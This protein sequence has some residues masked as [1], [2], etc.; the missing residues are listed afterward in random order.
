MTI[1]SPFAW[2]WKQLRTGVSLIGSES[3]EHYWHR[4][5]G[6]TSSL[7]VRKID[8]G[9]LR[10]ALAAGWADFAANRTDV[11]FLCVLYPIVGIVLSRLAF[12]YHL[13]PLLFPLA[14]GFALIG[15]IAGIGL[16][17]MSRRREAGENVSWVTAFSVLRAPSIGAITLLSFALMA[18]FLLWLFVAA[19]IYEVI[20]GSV[21]PVSIPAF[22][23]TVFGTGAGWALI[24][25]GCGVGF[26]FAALV[27]AIS[28]ISFPLLLDQNVG[29]ETAVRTSLRLVAT[30]PWTIALWGLIIAVALVLGS[31]PL[32]IG[33][34]VVMPVLGHATWHLYRRAVVLR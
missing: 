4:G 11:I 15:P 32:L 5:E 27:L 13:L 2:G 16:N 22:I 23:A 10:A 12:G 33:L 26:L 9:D 20:L 30:N 19:S 24:G 14:A 25:I 8:A 29:V 18:I 21:P 1:E 6:L 28:A 3:S 31:I 7:A 34:A 17:E